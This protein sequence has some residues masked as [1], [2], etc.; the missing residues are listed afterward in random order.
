[1]IVFFYASRHILYMPIFISSHFPTPTNPHTQI[2][3]TISFTNSS[4]PKFKGFLI[5]TEVKNQMKS[6]ARKKENYFCHYLAG[7]WRG[8][9]ISHNEY[10]YSPG[11]LKM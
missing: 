6:Q 4:L 7:G 8:G 11:M 2:P 1:M 3:Q 5:F 10:S 9:V